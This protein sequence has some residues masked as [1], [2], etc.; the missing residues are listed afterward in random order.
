M[1]NIVTLLRLVVPG[2]AVVAALAGEAQPNI[3]ATGLRLPTPAEQAWLEDRQVVTT[4]VLPNRLALDRLNAERRARGQPAIQAAQVQ[5]AADGAEIEGHIKGKPQLAL[6]ARLVPKVSNKASAALMAMPSSADNSS[7]IWFPPIRNQGSLGSC[8]AFSLAYYNF[9][10]QV[11]KELNRDVRNNT[12]NSDKFSPKFA[13]NLL[14]FG[15][16]GAVSENA[17][18]RVLQENGSPTWADWPY[19]GDFRA[20]PQTAALWRSALT[21]RIGNIGW[22]NTLAEA[23]SDLDV[24]KQ[25]LANGQLLNFGTCITGAIFRNLGNDPATA[26][27]DA[28]AGQ[29]VAIGQNQNT[30]DHEMTL[31]GYNDS[32][33]TDINSN[34]V[35]DNGEKGAFKAAN[36]WGTSHHNAGFLWIAYD[37]VRR[38]SQISGGPSPRYPEVYSGSWMS[39]RP[40]SAAPRV[41]GEITL[42]TVARNQLNLSLGLGDTAATAP[43]SSITMLGTSY[44]GLYGFSGTTSAVNA[45]LVFDLA[46]LVPDLLAHRLF[47][48]V[49]DTTSGSPCTISTFRLTDANG[50]QLAACSGTNPAGGLPRIADASTVHVWADYQLPSG[51]IIPPSAIS[52][53]AASSVTATTAILTWTAPGSDAS[54]GA[55]V[56]TYDVRY[57]AAPITNAS[58]AAAT[59]LVPPASSAIPGVTQTFTV[60]GLPSGQ[61]LWL[62]IKA[63]DA[64]GNWSAASNQVSIATTPLL[65][66][67]TPSVLPA[68]GVGSGYA[69][70]LAANGGTPAYTWSCPA[71]PMTEDSSGTATLTTGGTGLGMTGGMYVYSFSGFS[72]PLPNGDSS[73]SCRVLASGSL[74][75]LGS[76]GDSL[77]LNVLA[78]GLA[79]TQAAEDVFVSQG[80]GWLAFR[81]AAHPVGVTGVAATVNFQATL[82]ADGRIRYTYGSIAGIT[83]SPVINLVALGFS[84]SLMPSVRNGQSTITAGAT[85]LFIPNAIPPGMT[86]NPS[87]ATLGGTPTTAG[88]FTFRIRT[89]DSGTGANQ[90]TVTKTFSVVIAATNVAPVVVATIPNQ[91][92]TVGTAFSFTVPAGTFADANGDTLTWSA[93]GLPAGLSFNASTRVISGT[94]TA[95]GTSV[96]TVAVNDGHGHATSTV[97]VISIYSATGSGGAG[98]RANSGGGGAGC[99]VGGAIGMLGASL[100]MTFRLRRRRR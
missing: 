28:L 77:N 58:F 95:A 10:Y 66:I 97:C 13:Y 91:A 4:R 50:T 15:V 82:F 59:P 31:V 25:L 32:V 86:F 2:L 42:N 5:L 72:F 64:S 62:S 6:A 93:S 45:N 7:T 56:A 30:Q 80:A 11:A 35:V 20:I 55:K 17:V 14:N 22:V 75:L 36:S 51:D 43:V 29:Q 49:Q 52:D 41:F 44:A 88:N 23:D 54:G 63:R 92:G 76:S 70:T 57:A 18:H 33:W 98:S 19:D 24:I 48:S 61:T 81:W 3:G 94:P 96:L 68:G 78:T 69:A 27:D 67:T 99:G 47:I 21:Y 85:S 46:D 40:L 65:A 26:D 60:S 53:L 39:L 34:G 100:A 84:P 37:A 38:I 83:A 73:T 90:Q 16:N 71:F 74:A 9:T 12:V 8:V 79:Y 1:P 89:D 87:T